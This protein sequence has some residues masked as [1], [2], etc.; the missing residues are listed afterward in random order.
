MEQFCVPGTVTPA[1]KCGGG[2][3]CDPW[4]DGEIEAPRSCSHQAASTSRAQQSNPALPPGPHATHSNRGLAMFQ[5]GPGLWS[6]SQHKLILRPG[7]TGDGGV[8]R[9]H[10]HMPQD[11]FLA[12]LVLPFV[13]SQPSSLHGHTASPQQPSGHC[14]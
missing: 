3:R 12:S 14:P 5:Q 7:F 13:L 4:E 9:A 1:T 8:A 10:P 11:W 6:E 2:V